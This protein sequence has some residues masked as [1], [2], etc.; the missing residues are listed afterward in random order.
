MAGH[1]WR[2]QG[3]E[4]LLKPK[5][6]YR[7]VELGHGEHLTLAIRLVCYNHSGKPMSFRVVAP[8]LEAANG[9]ALLVLLNDLAMALTKPS[10]LESE[11]DDHVDA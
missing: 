5:S 7:V 8:R 1:G 11:F 9:D 4:L 3:H 6:D 2:G 10:L